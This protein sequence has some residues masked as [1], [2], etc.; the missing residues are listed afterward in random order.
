VQ[1]NRARFTRKP[2]ND[3][4]DQN[5]RS[6]IERWR[7]GQMAGYASGPKGAHRLRP[8]ALLTGDVFLFLCG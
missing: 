4:L 7:F 8:K 5:F 6:A 1:M 3:C 2:R